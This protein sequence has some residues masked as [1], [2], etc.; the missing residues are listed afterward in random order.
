MGNRF[1]PAVRGRRLTA[2]AREWIAQTP[3][4]GIGRPEE[5]ARV[6]A[7]L[8]SP[9]ASFVCGQSIVVDGGRTL[10]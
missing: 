4:G 5:I 9:A 7:C 1:F 8:C 6:I 10:W 2:R 3:A